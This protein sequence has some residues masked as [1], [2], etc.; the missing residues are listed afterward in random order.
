MNERT[1]LLA[2][3]SREDE[4]PSVDINSNSGYLS[5]DYD[6]EE[7]DTDDDEPLDVL[8][9]RYTSGENMNAP[10]LSGSLGAFSSSLRHRSSTMAFSFSALSRTTSRTDTLRHRPSRPS[11]ARPTASRQPSRSSLKP[12]FLKKTKT[13]QGEDME[14]GEIK[15]GGKYLVDIGEL[16][17]WAI[18][19]SIFLTWFVACFDSTLMAS[20]HPIISTYFDA[21]NEASWFSTSFLLTSS[22]FAP[23][24]ARVSDTWGRRVSLIFGLLAFG[25]GTLWCALAPT[26]LHFILARALCGLGAGASINQGAIIVS[27]LLPLRRRGAYLSW[28]NL[29]YGIGCSLGAALGGFLAESIGWRWVSVFSQQH[30]RI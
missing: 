10:G 18:F 14:A 24:F 27:D 22:S 12:A 28:L 4:G 5:T 11:M 19:V 21:S 26:I 16:R 7:D 23:I 29:S 15:T 30:N 2:R 25:F 1:A 13:A 3:E 17:F 8:V 20:S 6:S 9:D